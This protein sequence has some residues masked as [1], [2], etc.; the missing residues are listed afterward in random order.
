VTPYEHIAS[1]FHTRID[2]IAGAVDAL[3]PGLQAAAQQIV[4]AALNDQRILVCAGGDDTALG[5]YAGHLLRSSWG[6][7]PPLPAL[8]L[9]S[10]TD[11]SGRASLW[12]DVRTL[13]KDGDVLL[14]IDTAE[15]ALLAREAGAVAAERNLC[16]QLLSELTEL[17]GAGILLPL[18]SD[19]IT[20]RRELAL[21]SVHSLRELIADLLMGE[22]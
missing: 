15:N 18:N 7:A 11:D 12:R 9:G 14:C 22:Q 10:T 4:D 17:P 8:A 1:S 3:A 6:G 19:E 5:S 21:M 2:A 13:A 20:L 16:A